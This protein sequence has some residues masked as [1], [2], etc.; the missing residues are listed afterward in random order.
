MAALQDDSPAHS[1]TLVAALAVLAALA[2]TA[3]FPAFA[4]SANRPTGS[5]G[6]AGEAEAGIPQRKRAHEGGQPYLVAQRPLAPPVRP[7]SLQRVCSSPAAASDQA[8][9]PGPLRPR[10]ARAL[11][12]PGARGAVCQAHSREEVPPCELCDHTALGRR[13]RP[14]RPGLPRR[15]R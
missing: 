13:S 1:A 8:P 2:A 6:E 5:K 15:P 14:R 4:A 9:F 3:A 11:W 7:S 12:V 10:T